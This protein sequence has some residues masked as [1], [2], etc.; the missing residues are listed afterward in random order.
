VIDALIV[1]FWVYVLCILGHAALAASRQPA[2]PPRVGIRWTPKRM[3]FW[4]SLTLLSV[5]ALWWRL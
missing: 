3:A 4:S 1:L 5:V 2:P